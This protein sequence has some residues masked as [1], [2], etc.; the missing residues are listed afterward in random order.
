MVPL[1]WRAFKYQISYGSRLDHR[2][3]WSGGSNKE[4]GFLNRF[5]EDSKATNPQTSTPIRVMS[6]WN[7][8]LTKMQRS[9]FVCTATDEEARE[10]KARVSGQSRLKS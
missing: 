9:M 5:L 4:C 8:S 6:N 3:R 10:R 1:V 2:T 7:P